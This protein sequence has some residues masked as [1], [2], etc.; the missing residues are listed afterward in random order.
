MESDK[1]L[2]KDYFKSLQIIHFALMT[3]ILFFAIISFV[4]VT[5]GF[6]VS[7]LEDIESILAVFVPVFLIIGLVSGNFLYKL[8]I[9]EAKVKSSLWEKLTIYR[10]AFIIKLALAEGPAFFSVVIYLITGKSVYLAL[11]GLL[12]IVFA[13]YKPSREKLITDLELN[14]VDRQIMED[15]EGVIN[16]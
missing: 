2:S 15:P 7:G 1:Q 4:V 13:V 5:Q 10:G 3:G 6:E 12:L 11:T 8:K 9:N 16:R 14:Y